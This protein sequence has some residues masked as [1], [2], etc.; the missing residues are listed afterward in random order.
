MKR[1][2]S[3]ELH[4]V[5]CALA[6][7]LRAIRAGRFERGAARLIEALNLATALP[8]GSYEQSNAFALVEA[9]A[10]LGY[11]LQ[12]KEKAQRARRPRLQLAS[13]SR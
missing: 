13:V 2:P 12:E 9:L 4:G 8:G 5:A 10:V 7:T 6:R 11:E 3:H 1:T